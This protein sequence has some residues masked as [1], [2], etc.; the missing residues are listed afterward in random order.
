[1]NIIIDFDSTFIQLEGLDTLAEIALT[2]SPNAKEIVQEIKEITNQGMEGKI[3]FSESLQKRLKLLNANREHLPQLIEKLKQNVTESFQRNR[4][5][6]KNYASNIYILS[7]GFKDFIVPVVVEFGIAE[8]QVFAN[9]FTFDEDGNITGVDTNSPLSQ[10]NGKI[11]QVKA[12]GLNGNTVVIGDGLTDYQIR[13]AGLARKFYAFIENVE[14][15]SVVEKADHVTP[16]LDEFLFANQL[17]RAMSYPKNR[18][19]VLILENIHQ[20]AVDTFKKEGY[21]VEVI[22]GGL[23]ENELCEK[24][25]DV[26]VIGIRSKTQ[27]TAKVLEHANKLIAVGAFC[28]GTNQ[29]DLETCLEKGVVAFNAPFSNTRSV[30]ELAIGQ[31]IMLMRNIFPFSNK[32]H[33]G[34][35]NKSAKG[36]HEIR[37]KK[38]GIIGYGNIGAQLSV[39]AE[40]MG[41]DVYYYDI[42]EKLALGN[43]TKCNTIDE[44]LNVADIV[45]LHVDGRPE[46]KNFFTAEMFEQMKDGAIFMNL[47]RGFVVD[48]PALVERLKSGKIK[49]AS[50]DVFPKEPKTNQ[51]PFVSELI[52]LPNMILT[53]HIG[54]STL[55][56]QENIAAFVPSHLINFI[57]KG[58]TFGSVNFPNLKLPEQQNAHRLIH[59]HEN[60]S[61]I[62][63]KINQVFA[64]HEVNI[65]GQYLKT[66][67]KIGYVITDIDKVYKEG[68][69]EEL[70]NIENTIRFRILY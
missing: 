2:N 7:N 45:T 70:R 21:A 30:V 49:G 15:P 44:V 29:I 39:L 62:L 32:M 56:A 53:P 13:E 16:N 47:S 28:I 27:I 9:T 48:V 63:A 40:S 17:Q 5:F 67:E 35:W 42:V 26:S 8:K 54:G 68:L 57:D 38:L 69:T 22:N 31:M 60:V 10:D 58:D 11:T 46:N 43:A 19:K 59:I 55:E 4:E 41:L 20:D 12:L 64:K 25:K 23:D 52:G 66:N 37:G 51:E 36:S 18:I 34:V 50:V 3:P 14:R 24:I 33:E 65:L 1:M 61:G 6:L